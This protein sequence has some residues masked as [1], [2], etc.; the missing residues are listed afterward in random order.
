MEIVIQ[1]LAL[2]IVANSILKL[3]FRKLWQAFALG[4]LCAAFTVGACR[5]V[6]LQ[7]KTQWDALLNDPRIMQNA[8]VLV[9]IE[10]LVCFTFCFL[11][12][13]QMYGRKRGK[14]W[15]RLPGWYP[16]LLIFP[17]LFYAQA[18][19]I[20]RMPGANFTLISWALAAAVAIG[21]PL[22]A[23]LARWL[24]P[25]KPFRLE[26]H[27]LVSFFV[28]I[29]GL[30]ATEDGNVAYAAVKEPLHLQSLLPLLAVFASL[31]AAGWGWYKVKWR[32]KQKRIIKN[33]VI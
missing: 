9:T 28:C 22:F 3:S 16:G 19:I 14:W 11:E 7:S 6:I 30:I 31:F 17:V 18:Q 4:L 10:S 26:V 24:Y 25:E 2:F 33:K 20:F 1:V 13:Q 27:F 5:W 12:L 32:I 23:W 8:A 29:L 21:L 15:K